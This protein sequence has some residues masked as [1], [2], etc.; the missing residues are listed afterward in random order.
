MYRKLITSTAVLAL[1]IN[2]I[3]P[4]KADGFSSR[5]NRAVSQKA[6]A[7]S[8]VVKKHLRHSISREAKFKTTARSLARAKASKRTVSRPVHLENPEEEEMENAVPGRIVAAP[9]RTRKATVK[10]RRARLAGGRGRDAIKIATAPR[11]AGGA[12]IKCTLALGECGTKVGKAGYKGAKKVG[13]VVAK[14]GKSV[15]R[16][17]V[18]VGKGVGRTGKLLVNTAVNQVKSTVGCALALGKCVVRAKNNAVKIGKLV[19][20]GAVKGGKAVGR[21]AFRVGKNVGRAGKAAG[22]GVAKG[23]KAVGRGAFRVARGVG[24]S[25]KAAVKC[26]LALGKCGTK[27]GKA[28]A[29]GTKKVGRS[30]KKGAKKVGRGAKKVAKKLK[31]W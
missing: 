1:T 6:F 8:V 30:V 21:G 24:R 23:G 5:V 29:K 18:R 4:A 3:A 9:P 17:A 25:G 16:G 15:G 22:R 14:A 19:G 20:R 31:F 27:V 7:Q 26:T 13:R 10:N 11:R 12:V 2:L 28:V